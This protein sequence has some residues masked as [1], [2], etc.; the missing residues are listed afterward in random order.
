[1]QEEFLASFVLMR[2]CKRFVVH[3]IKLKLAGQR[4]DLGSELCIEAFKSIFKKILCKAL[5][6]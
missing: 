3:K 4:S 1:M 5:S 2:S 6:F